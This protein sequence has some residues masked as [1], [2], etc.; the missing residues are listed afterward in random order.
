[1]RY[2]SPAIADVLTEMFEAGVQK[3]AVLPLYPQYGGPTTG[4]TFDE[5]SSDLTRRRWLP[6]LRFISS[7]H[8]DPRYIA[9]VA[10]SIRATGQHMG[11]QTNWCCPTTVCPS[12]ICSRATLSLSVPQNVS[13]LLASNWTCQKTR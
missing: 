12:G 10:D 9:A 8:D 11:A 13:T 6:A 7:Y 5:V 4:S 2:G 3:L 1:M